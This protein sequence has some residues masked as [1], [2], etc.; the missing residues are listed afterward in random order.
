NAGT[1]L[2]ISHALRN[3]ASHIDAVEPHRTVAKL[4]LNELA[5]DNDSLF[6]LP[7]IKMHIT[8]PRSFLSSTNKKYGLIQLPMIGAFGGGV[9]LYAM[10]EEYG[11]T[12]EAFLK[13]WNLLEEDGVI[14]ITSWMDYPFRNPLKITATLSEILEEAGITQHRSHITAVR[15]WATVTYLLKKSVFT[16]AD[17]AAIRNFCAAYFFDPLLLPGLKQEERMIHNGI[18]DSSFF[19]YTDELLAGNRKKFYAEYGFHIKPANDDKPYFS[20]FLRRKSLPHLS[21]VFGSQNIS[22]IELGWLISV[23]T[24][25][26]ITLMAVLLIVA[27]LFKLRS[28]SRGSKRNWTLLYFS[29]L[30]IGYMFFEIVLI[31]KFILFFGNPVYA[32]A[33]VICVMLLASGAGSYYS[34]R[35]LP[36]PKVMQRI[37]LMI[38]LLLLGYTFGLRSLLHQIASVPE[39]LRIIISM[40]II[41]CPAFLM[42]MPFPL[43]LRAQAAI[44]EKNIPWAW[45]INGC[46]SVISASLATLLTVE[47]GFSTVIMLAAIC[48]AVSMMS[49]WLVRGRMNS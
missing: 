18:S 22:F 21:N 26:Q 47:T 25:L 11:L 41:A 20:Q 15:G 14:S 29:G 23:I 34:S 6:Y 19:V 5:A 24:F 32:S 13:M 35:L 46:M 2:H 12:K 40:L 10:R 43:G 7:Q 9:G 8:E 36:A 17:T 16:D 37:L 27:P 4:L 45:G 49:V 3:K 38:F 42:G 48:Y 1:G 44:E 31:Q 28:V 39:L 33:V 30:G